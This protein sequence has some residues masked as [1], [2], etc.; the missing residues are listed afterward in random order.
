[1]MMTT[2]NTNEGVEQIN[3]IRKFLLW[4]QWAGE[5]ESLES[6]KK[7]SAKFKAGLLLPGKFGKPGKVG[8]FSWCG[9]F[10]IIV[11]KF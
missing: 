7:P 1:M 10:L 9:K 5:P 11:T 3:T 6:G 4:G 2:I 8:E